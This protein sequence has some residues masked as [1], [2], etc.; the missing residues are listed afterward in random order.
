MTKIEQQHLVK[1]RSS[2]GSSTEKQ[3]WPEITEINESANT[4]K[5]PYKLLVEW[6]ITFMLPLPTAVDD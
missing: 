6:W 5:Q 4:V 1:V 2:E 3:P